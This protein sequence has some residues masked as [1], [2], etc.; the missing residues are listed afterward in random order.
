MKTRL[1]C[2]AAACLAMQLISV[3]APAQN[4]T[5]TKTKHAAT[6]HVSK[7]AS[8][9]GSWIDH[10]SKNVNHWMNGT[11]KKINKGTNKGSK[12]INHTFQGK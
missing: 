3:T 2:I 9:T 10:G 4:S 12:K 6:G 8:K 7:A 1:F 11:S 5:N